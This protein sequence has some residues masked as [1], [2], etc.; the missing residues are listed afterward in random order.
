MHHTFR[1][2]IPTPSFSLAHQLCNCG[3]ASATRWSATHWLSHAPLCPSLS[4]PLFLPPLPPS[5]PPLPD[6]LRGRAGR[7]PHDPRNSGR[8]QEDEKTLASACQCLKF[9]QLGLVTMGKGCLGEC[10][11]A[12]RRVPPFHRIP[13]QKVAVPDGCVFRT[14]K[15]GDPPSSVN[16]SSSGAPC[17]LAQTE[18]KRIRQMDATRRTTCMLREHVC[19][20][21]SNYSAEAT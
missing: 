19:P 2:K 17:V 20:N 21:T 15:K 8:D 9:R 5:L 12:G 1:P 6:A 18:N 3:W 14:P 11:G 13:S 4:L 7:K 16:S 10:G